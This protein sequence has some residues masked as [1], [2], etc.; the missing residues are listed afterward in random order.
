M[1]K[2]NLT[3]KIAT[4]ENLSYVYG[5]PCVDEVSGYYVHKIYNIL[6]QTRYIC[7]YRCW[8]APKCDATQVINVIKY[9]ENNFDVSYDLWPK[10]YYACA[11]VGQMVFALSHS[12]LYCMARS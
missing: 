9:M 4:K 6:Y 12:A 8:T 11:V 10:Y 1:W 2:K 5:F 3:V 7:V